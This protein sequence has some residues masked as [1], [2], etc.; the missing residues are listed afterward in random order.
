MLL[1][2]IR[3]LKQ[4]YELELQ[5]MQQE[6]QKSLD[7]SEIVGA[8]T[9]G[10]PLKVVRGVQRAACRGAERLFTIVPPEDIEG[11]HTRLSTSM[12]DYAADLE[13]LAHQVEKGTMSFTEFS[14]TLSHLESA[15]RLRAAG[16]EIRMMGY[17]MAAT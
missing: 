1:V 14:A 17:S 5:E 16:D 13:R 3:L 15:E 4:D 8:I 7:P 9:S 12:R 2:D 10:T 11:A 6:I